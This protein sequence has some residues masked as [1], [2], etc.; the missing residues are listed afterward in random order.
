MNTASATAQAQPVLADE[1]IVSADSHIM[2]PVD[3]WEKN[4]TPTLKDKYPKFP[5]RNSPGEKPGGWDPR[6]RLGEMEVDGVSAEVLYPTFGLRLF[7]LEDAA[8]QEACF[9]I[10]NDWLIDYC[11]V[12]PGRLVGI[13][14]IS[15]YNIPN[16]IKELERCKKAGL[17]GSLIWQVPPDRLSFTS[18]YY[19]P[20][21]EAS[22]DLNMPVNLHILTGFNYSRFERK[23]L[24]IF[25]ATV[26]TKVYDAANSLFDLVFSGVMERF[27]RLK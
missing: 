20:F 21:W 16:A 19:D 1:R 13:P 10:A 11:R 27:P 6:A 12:A 4:L 25:R 22:Q 26:N 3:L 15:L 23:G 17:V 9:R 18:N 8:L 5:P 14:M 24:D 2:E 7:A